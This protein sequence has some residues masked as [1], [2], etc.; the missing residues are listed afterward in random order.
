MM[1]CG[2]NL[3]Y[4]IRWLMRP[5]S[6]NSFLYVFYFF[7][8]ILFFFIFVFLFLDTNKLIGW[9]EKYKIPF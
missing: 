9:L 5:F 2:E 4:S 7:S 1:V 8:I 3:Y 6:V